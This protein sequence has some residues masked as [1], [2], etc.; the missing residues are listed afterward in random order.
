MSLILCDIDGTCANLTHRL[1]FVQG[2]QKNWSMFLDPAIVA[3]DT[4]M[5]GTRA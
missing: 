3:L 5:E 4:P 1:M 2:T